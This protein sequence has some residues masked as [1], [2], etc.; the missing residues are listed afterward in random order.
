MVN[1]SNTRDSRSRH[2]VLG[3]VPDI[4]VTS[5]AGPSSENVIS[6]SSDCKASSYKAKI[7]KLLS[8]QLL[9]YLGKSEEKEPSEENDYWRRESEDQKWV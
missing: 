2:S 7:A 4:S 3:E 5:K 6:E 1:L 9:E 8:L